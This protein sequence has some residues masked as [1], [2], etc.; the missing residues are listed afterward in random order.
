M[1]IF[2]ALDL[3]DGALARGTGRAT[4]F[5]AVFDSTLDRLS[6]AAVLAGLA[7]YYVQSGSREEVVLCFAAL[8]GSI[9]VSYVRARAQFYGLD[10]TDGLFTRPERVL[11]LGGGLI[12]SQV[13]IA[14]WI[15]AVMANA[16]ALQRLYVVWDRFR[17]DPPP[18]EGRPIHRG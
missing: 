12:I 10:L 11:V 1:L 2:S 13:R 14:L 8:T 9:L 6:E 3:L 16:T 5:G 7:F 15:L 17:R 18:P 4:A